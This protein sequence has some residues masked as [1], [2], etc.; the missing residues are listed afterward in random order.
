MS[1]AYFSQKGKGKGKGKGKKKGPRP[2]LKATVKVT[3]PEP[4][5]LPNTP[6][7]KTFA[8]VTRQKQS[9]PEV[10][11]QK[12][13]LPSTTQH[14]QPLTEVA[15]QKPSFTEV[16][17]QKQPLILTQ[18]VAT[19]SQP[20]V[21]YRRQLDKSGVGVGKLQQLNT[22][23]LSTYLF[24]AQLD[25]LRE[26]YEKNPE[27]SILCPQYKYG[28]V[29]LG[30]SGSVKR[31]EKCIDSA[32]RELIEES[33]L[34]AQHT[35]FIEKSCVKENGKQI[36]VYTTNALNCQRSKIVPEN[37]DRDKSNLKVIIIVSGTSNEIKDLLNKV[38]LLDRTENINSYCSVPLKYIAE[39]YKFN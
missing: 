35:S 2:G 20:N 28:D 6:Q 31:K 15:Q 34:E 25:S 38:K 13:T 39:H 12:Q 5:S 3:V 17:K 27:N 1:S 33:G 24:N 29:Q 11:Q 26:L 16:L 22:I 10:V 36:R 8:D 37:K 14:K 30:F 19:A 21:I 23:I 18:K 32:Y 4:T 9:P 7:K